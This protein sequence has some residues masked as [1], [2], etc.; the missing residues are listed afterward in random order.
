MVSSRPPKTFGL[1]QILIGYSLYLA[2]FSAT[3]TTK[4]WN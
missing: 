1:V 3:I 2:K 4:L